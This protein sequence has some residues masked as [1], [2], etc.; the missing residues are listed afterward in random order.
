M[1]G[2]VASPSWPC[3][4]GTPE[5]TRLLVVEPE[6]IAKSAPPILT[7]CPSAKPPSAQTDPSLLVTVLPATITPPPM[8]NGNRSS[9]RSACGFVVLLEYHLPSCDVSP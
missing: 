3:T 4:A 6:T 7:S 2:F 8:V 1:G 9:R 5:S